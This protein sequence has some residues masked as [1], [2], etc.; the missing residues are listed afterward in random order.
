MN[1]ACIDLVARFGGEYRISRDPA[2]E[3]RTDPWMAQIPCQRGII[4]PHGGDMLAVEV[5]GRPITAGKLAA[6]GLTLHQDGDREKTFLFPV[7]GFP[8][9]AAIV[10]PRKRRR[11][12]PEQRQAAIERLAGF[13]FRPARQSN[14]GERQGEETQ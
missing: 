7:E 11:Q 4:Y 1:T 10:L 6:L 12:T 2:A 9:V 3:G 8:E 13:Q 14:G 5:D